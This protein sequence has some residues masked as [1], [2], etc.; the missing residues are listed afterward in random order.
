M[1]AR[2]ESCDHA[3]S[4]MWALFGEAA[5]HPGPQP[6]GIQGML[7]L[8][9]A[10]PENDLEAR[11]TAYRFAPAVGGP[12][13]TGQRSAPRQA[14]RRMTANV[15]PRG[16]LLYSALVG[17]PAGLLATAHGCR[18]SNTPAYATGRSSRR[19]QSRAGWRAAERRRPPGRVSAVGTHAPTR[20]RPRN[21]LHRRR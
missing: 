16:R 15:D 17:E 2:A 6:L 5:A 8:I 20:S 18:L 21:R 4:T 1:G 7:G 13:R 19:G 9:R 10:T 12:N 14:A 11:V 3:A